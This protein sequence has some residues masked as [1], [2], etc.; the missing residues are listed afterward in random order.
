VKVYVSLL[1]AS[2]G[3]VVPQLSWQPG[4]ALNYAILNEEQA[5]QHGQAGEQ[6]GIRPLV[7]LCHDVCSETAL[8]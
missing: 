3:R 6:L 7:A 2:L 5:R 8:S 4:H 1:A